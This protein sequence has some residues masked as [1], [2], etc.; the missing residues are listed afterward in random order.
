[1]AE[2]STSDSLR[3]RDLP[4]FSGWFTLVILLILVHCFC[5]QD[6]FN[7]L[8]FVLI[9]FG[10]CLFLLPA[11]LS[12]LSPSLFDILDEVL[13]SCTCQNAILPFQW[14]SSLWSHSHVMRLIAN[15]HEIG[16]SRVDNK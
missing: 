14:I 4:F 1:M 10:T 2:L 7:C 3:L 9:A 8:V 13:S 6:S 16:S 15:S 12:V 5:E 11:A